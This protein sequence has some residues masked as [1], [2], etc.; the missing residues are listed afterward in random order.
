MQHLWLHHRKPTCSFATY[1]SLINSIQFTERNWNSGVS[2][3]NVLQH[4]TLA[5]NADI[6]YIQ[7]KRRE[8][9]PYN[10]CTHKTRCYL[11]KYKFQSSLVKMLFQSIDFY[12]ISLLEFQ[13]KVYLVANSVNLAPFLLNQQRHE[14]IRFGE[15]TVNCQDVLNIMDN[16]PIL[17]PYSIAVFSSYSYIAN[18]KQST[19]THLIGW[20]QGNNNSTLHIFLT[21]TI[22]EK[23]CTLTY[24][25]SSNT[26][27]NLYCFKNFYSYSHITEGENQNSQIYCALQKD[28]LLNQDFCVCEHSDT[29]D[30]YVP[31]NH[32]FK[33]LG[34]Y[35][36]ALSVYVYVYD[37]LLALHISIF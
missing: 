28:Q 10:N 12:P 4:I 3:N 13:N 35:I 18:T 2:L 19:K 20:H 16:I 14:S 22:N 29:N 6:N 11:F 32:N 34:E 8:N 26:H 7:F 1:K 33:S 17:K 9:K 27:K 24:L 31:G 15:D 30:L 36:I 23:K 5:I 21:P 25:N 37:M